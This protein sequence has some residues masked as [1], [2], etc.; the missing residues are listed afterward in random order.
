MALPFLRKKHE[1]GVIVKYRNPDEASADQPVSPEEQ[2]DAALET[3]ADEILKAVASNDK[4][5]LAAAIRS[6]F[7]VLES[8]PHEEPGEIENDSDFEDQGE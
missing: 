4:R 2:D 6:A 1:A 3:C 5:A 8:E 7:T